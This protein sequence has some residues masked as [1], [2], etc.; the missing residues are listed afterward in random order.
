M[1]CKRL[2]VPFLLGSV[3]ACGGVDDTGSDRDAL[4]SRPTCSAIASNCHGSIDVTGQECHVAAHAAKT[5]E[6][7]CL[8]MR[9]ECLAICGEGGAHHGH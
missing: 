6:T 5:T 2:F 4:G 3:A 7:E 9:D 1:I 8:A